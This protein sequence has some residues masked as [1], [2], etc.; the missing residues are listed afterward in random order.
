MKNIN[1]LIL[2]FLFSCGGIDECR[3]SVSIP[4]LNKDYAEILD[5]SLCGDGTVYYELRIQ[6]EFSGKFL[7]NS[8]YV[9]S[10]GS[11][12]TVFRGDNY[13]NKFALEYLPYGEICGDLEF[14]VILI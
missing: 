2:L 8:H 5:F 14:E 11:I 7:I 9:Q 12:D 13:G 10:D 1:Y 6:G 3:K 4:D